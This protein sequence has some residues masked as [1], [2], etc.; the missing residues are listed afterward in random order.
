[1][2]DEFFSD[3]SVMD[4]DIARFKF[5]LRGTRGVSGSWSV[6]QPEKQG[7]DFFAPNN[8]AKFLKGEE[9]DQG[10]EHD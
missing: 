7:G 4:Q 3:Q 8:P 10:D 5:V 1:M 2:S 6:P 9:R